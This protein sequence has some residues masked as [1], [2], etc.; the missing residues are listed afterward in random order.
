MNNESEVRIS[1]LRK[2]HKHNDEMKIMERA[3]GENKKIFV[4]NIPIPKAIVRI[5]IL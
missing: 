4:V 5:D 1:F 3:R 2:K